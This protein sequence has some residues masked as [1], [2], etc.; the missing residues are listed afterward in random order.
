LIKMTF[1][2]FTSSTKDLCDN[3][4][5]KMIST[6]GGYWTDGDTEFTTS[7]NPPG[8]CLKYYNA[9]TGETYYIALVAGVVGNSSVDAIEAVLVFFSTGWNSVNHMPDGTV[10]LTMIP[11][12]RRY[13]AGLSLENKTGQAWMWYDDNGFTMLWKT[14]PTNRVDYVTLFALER[15]TSKEYSDGYTNFFLFSESAGYNEMPLYYDVYGGSARW[16][17]AP[18]SWSLPAGWSTLKI[19]ISKYI[20]PFGTELPESGTSCAD[21]FNFAEGHDW[22][23]L[24]WYNPIRAR[25]SPGNAKV[26]LGFGWAFNDTAVAPEGFKNFIKKI[27]TFFAVRAGT[28]LAD[29]DIINVVVGAETWQYIY[30][31]I[32]SPDG[33]QLDVAI[34]YA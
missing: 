20:H 4:A 30:K 1:E 13:N 12:T 31:S 25:K 19:K 27:K 11:I 3:I 2:T 8:R 22:D 10:K 32:V 33:G 6:S 7:G 15:D 23:A 18:Q 26:Y 5:N 21:Y 17:G 9:E 29:G 14:D 16:R 28:G 24:M 34:R